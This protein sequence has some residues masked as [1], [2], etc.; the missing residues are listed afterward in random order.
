LSIVGEYLYK[1]KPE[2]DYHKECSLNKVLEE[3]NVSMAKNNEVLKENCINPFIILL[4]RI[5]F[6]NW[7]VLQVIKILGRIKDCLPAFMA[8]LLSM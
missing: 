2:A 7:K 1:F 8:G 3:L 6:L 4:M 5:I